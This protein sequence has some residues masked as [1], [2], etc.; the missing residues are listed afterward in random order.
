MKN[1][2]LVTIIL[3][4]APIVFALDGYNLETGEFINIDK[5]QLI[6]P[7]EEIEFFNYNTGEYE[8]KEVND[9]YDN[10]VEIF[11]VET[12]EYNFFDMDFD[13]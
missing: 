5:N 7:G 9:I 6:R 1:L 8:F 10:T 4:F 12:G 2:L 13:L 3:F 11:D